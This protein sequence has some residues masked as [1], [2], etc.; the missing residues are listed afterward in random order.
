MEDCVDSED[1][2]DTDEEGARLVEVVVELG[3]SVE[4]FDVENDV[5][6]LVVEVDVVLVG[7]VSDEVLVRV[8][9]DGNS[10]EDVRVVDVDEFIAS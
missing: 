1:T 7:V 4:E 9:V 2:E 8:D 10:V 5:E 6:V 3:G